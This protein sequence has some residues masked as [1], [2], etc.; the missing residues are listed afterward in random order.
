M[1]VRHI[2]SAIAM[3][4]VMLGA[5]ATECTAGTMVVRSAGGRI[6]EDAAALPYEVLAAR[7][8]RRQNASSSS[9]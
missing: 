6:R 7:A 8:S 9:P 4:A 2:L 3:A 5:S 1:R